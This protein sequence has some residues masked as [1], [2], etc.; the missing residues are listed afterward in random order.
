MFVLIK[1]DFSTVI[2]NI[3]VMKFINFGK[4]CDIFDLSSALACSV[5]IVGN[6]WVPDKT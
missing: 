6:N 5:E 2:P 4:Y 1:M 3:I